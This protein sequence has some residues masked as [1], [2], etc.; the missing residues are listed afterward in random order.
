VKNIDFY[1][2][3]LHHLDQIFPAHLATHSVTKYH[4]ITKVTTFI[5]QTIVLILASILAHMAFGECVPG[6]S[7]LLQANQWVSNV[8]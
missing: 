4:Q 8:R 1:T 2:V 3:N 6:L 5:F 7:S